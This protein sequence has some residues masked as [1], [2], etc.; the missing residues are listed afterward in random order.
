MS[1]SARVQ[2][3]HTNQKAGSSRRAVGFERAIR[4]IQAANTA[5]VQ[6][7]GDAIG[8]LGPNF[9]S[10][11]KNHAGQTNPPGARQLFRF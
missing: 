5:Q 10:E 8:T 7:G 3:K 1:L 6:S 4:R 11:H 9:Y 2:S